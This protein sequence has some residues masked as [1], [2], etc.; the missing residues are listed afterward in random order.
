MAAAFCGP[1]AELGCVYE[2]HDAAVALFQAGLARVPEPPE[3]ADARYELEL[4]RAKLAAARGDGAIPLLA[5]ERTH[6]TRHDPGAARA[7]PLGAADLT[8]SPP[9]VT[10]GRALLRG[11][12]STTCHGPDASRL[13]D[14]CEVAATLLERFPADVASSRPPIAPAPRVAP[15]CS[16]RATATSCSPPHGRFR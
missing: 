5:L 8:A 7:F 9:R 14:S 6:A 16:R 15:Y 1:P 12:L 4:V 3:T 13:R 11:F 2:L 10:E